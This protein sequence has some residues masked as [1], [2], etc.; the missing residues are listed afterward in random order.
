MLGLAQLLR[1]ALLPGS[2]VYLFIQLE[3]A[4]IIPRLLFHYYYAFERNN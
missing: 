4:F 3:T 1:R 2:S